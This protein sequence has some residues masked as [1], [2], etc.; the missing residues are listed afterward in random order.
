MKKISIPFLIFIVGIQ[1]NCSTKN[2]EQREKKSQS[3]REFLVE[4][5]LSTDIKVPNKFETLQPRNKYSNHYFHFSTVLPKDFE[6]D[7]GNFE[8]TVIRAYDLNTATTVSIG[9]ESNSYLLDSK[10]T[11]ER[12]KKF[13]EGPLEYMNEIFSGDYKNRMLKVLTDNS[14]LEI[15]SIQVGELKIRN[16]NYVFLKYEYIEHYNGEEIE[17]VKLDYQTLLWDN[18]F[19]FSYNSPKSLHDEDLILDVLYNTNFT[20]QF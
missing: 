6:I 9:V 20:K 11:E 19:L 13:Q 10:K 12:H 7:R 4:N 18:F 16:T 8:N 1:F 15:S 3:F 14:N 2:I 5:D 17:I